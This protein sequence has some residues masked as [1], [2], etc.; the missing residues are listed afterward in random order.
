METATLTPCFCSPT[1]LN[2][3]VG[4]LKN[5]LSL[6]CAR[7]ATRNLSG[8]VSSS[9]PRATVRALRMSTV[10]ESSPQDTVLESP[11]SQPLFQ[12][13]N[14]KAI[15]PTVDIPVSKTFPSQCP[16]CFEKF[17]ERNGYVDMTLN[18]KRFV[19]P[20]PFTPRRQALFE[21]SPIANIYERGWRDRFAKA[22]FP[23]PDMEADMALDF[24]LPAKRMLDVSC[25]SGILTRRLA[26]S[27]S[28]DRLIATDISHPMLKEAVKLVRKDVRLPELDFVRADVANLPFADQ[29]F[30][31][32]H[33][34]AAIH[35]WPCVQDGLRE[36]RRI[37]VPGGKFFA[38]TFYN[39]AYVNDQ[40][41]IFLLSL[42]RAVF[43]N[44]G[45]EATFFFEENELTYL[46][47]AA[48]F[49]SVDIEKRSGCAIIRAV[50]GDN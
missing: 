44:S 10:S 31:A 41:L 2:S 29:S 11:T 32:V 13:P 45:D 20:L 19:L 42:R 27:N 5:G 4:H 21:L 33:A 16:S 18:P 17:P 6:V 7:F 48:G 43:G 39:D 47:R 12:C 38:T 9:R 50:K 30:D 28:V 35:C 22:G 14:C 36:I 23:G 40:I 15:L 34:G 26:A 37:L 3:R 24:L 8:H 49:V 1:I 46:F 25:G